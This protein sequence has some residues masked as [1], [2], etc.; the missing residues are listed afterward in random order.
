[1]RHWVIAIF[2]AHFL[3]GLV[4]FAFGP[5]IET[6]ERPLQVIADIEAPDFSSTRAEAA[7]TDAS[8]GHALVDD[9]PE[10]PDAVQRASI[11]VRHPAHTPVW[12]L[13]KEAG[14]P[15]PV[16]ASLDRPPR[17]V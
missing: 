10:L 13:F 3:L 17:L 14:I 2:T 4:G 12:S 15:K 8:V 11:Q 6:A 7:S 5:L 16:L 9:I 1:M